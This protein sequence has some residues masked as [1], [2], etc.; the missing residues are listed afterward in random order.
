MGVER[1]GKAHRATTVWVDDNSGL[2]LTRLSFANNGAA[3]AINAGTGATNDPVSV[4]VEMCSFE[5]QLSLQDDG[6]FVEG[7]GTPSTYF[8]RNWCTNTGKGALRWDLDVKPP[9]AEGGIGDGMSTADLYDFD[10]GSY[11]VA[12][13]RLELKID[14]SDLEAARNRAAKETEREDAEWR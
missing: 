2:A 9:K 13:P 3:Q 4:R 5:A 14:L 7:G 12:V 6:S 1:Q 10:I 11:H 8:R